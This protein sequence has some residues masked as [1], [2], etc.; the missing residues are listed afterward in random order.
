MVVTLIIPARASFGLKDIITLRH[1]E[2]MARSSRDGLDGGYAYIT[3]FFIAWYS[4][5]QYEQFTFLNRAFGPTPGRTGS[6]SCNVISPQLF[7]FKK[8]RTGRCGDDVVGQRSWS[9]SACG[10]SAS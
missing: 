4:G 5:E 2:N 9:T 7:W 3:E 1:L 10:S 6:W 8:L